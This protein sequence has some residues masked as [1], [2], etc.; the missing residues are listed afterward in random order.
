MNTEFEMENRK[1]VTS[2]IVTDNLCPATIAHPNA[3]HKS[4]ATAAKYAE[5][6][7]T[8]SNMTFI[9]NEHVAPHPCVDH[10]VSHPLVDATPPRVEIHTTRG[11]KI[12]GC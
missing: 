1:T 9:V 7:K 6:Q 2:D 4:A 10:V 12:I 8:C 5:R 3:A 11:E